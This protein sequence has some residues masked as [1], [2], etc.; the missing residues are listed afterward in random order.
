MKRRLGNTSRRF[1]RLIVES[2]ETRELMAA[3]VASN[4]W[5]DVKNGPLAKTGQQTIELLSKFRQWQSSAA[6]N[7]PNAQFSTPANSLAQIQDNSV[8]MEVVATDFPAA[9]TWLQNNGMVIQSSDPTY[10][11]INGNVPMLN[12]EAIARSSLVGSMRIIERPIVNAV[13]TVGDG[14]QTNVG[15]VQSQADLGQN[16]PSARST[17]A[18]TGAGVKVGVLSDSVSRFQGGLADSQASNNLGA[19]QVI[20]DGPTGSTDEGRAMLELVKD[21]APG[22]PLAFA[23][24]FVGGQTGFANNIDALRT[25]GAKVIVDDITYF[26][27]PMFQP[28]VIDLAIKRAVDANIPYFSS[29][30]NSGTNGL[31]LPVTGTWNVGTNYDFLAGTG[32][33]TKLRVTISSS[34]IFAFQ[35]DDPYNGIAAPG[36][37]DTDIDMFFYNTAGSSIGSIITNNIATGVP[38]EVFQ[39]NG[40]GSFDVSLK[41]NAGTKPTRMKLVSFD[42]NITTE[43]AASHS[44]TYGHNAGPW[45]I[46]VGAVPFYEAP[47]FSPTLPIL[48]E[49]FTSTGPSTYVYDGVTQYRKLAKNITY[50][51]PFISGID[52]ANT[53]FFGSDI[54]QDSDSF[55][56]FAGT[57]AAAPN[58]AAVAAL[59]KQKF[60]TARVNQIAQ[61]L[62]DSARPVNGAADGV[63]NN[64]GGY[65][66]IDAKAALTLLQTTINAGQVVDN[67]DVGFSAPANWANSTGASRYQNDGV[68]A[69]SSTTVTRAAYSF[70]Y[71]PKGTY[72]VMA[73]W[74]PAAAR[75]NAVKY[76]FFDGDQTETTAT[77]NQKVAPVGNSFS[78][79]TWGAIKRVV[80]TQG[81]LFVNVLSSSTGSVSA[82]AI[83]LVFVSSSVAAAA[84]APLVQAAT[85]QNV[86]RMSSPE[87]ESV[88]LNAS[89]SS[90]A[91]PT[92]ANGQTSKTSS[93]S[94]S[95]SV[96]APVPNASKSNKPNTL[97]IDLAL[98]TL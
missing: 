15:S 51:N 49:S 94:V 56:N 8:A 30:G 78:G 33:D 50:N 4:D 52:K 19:V 65:G 42:G 48:T 85:S 97:A 80:I 69:P 23:T 7:S 75:S 35:W 60:P 93:A 67:G 12:L 54:P 6:A 21:I 90:L 38:G 55:P 27:E 22:S 70:F 91:A 29:A 63:W 86:G 92:A 57:S 81:S 10:S 72:D 88:A 26:A 31:E 61:A 79:L 53:S 37:V 3:D 40:S 71:L 25:A 64:R 36:K 95:S 20:Q 13:Q 89:Q 18:V 83:R 68:I 76:E 62:A 58:V 73:R 17:F 32:V 9:L 28:G 82:D 59:M 39:F 14:A 11:V 45:T 2:L 96:S 24:A 5:L 66:L 46:G 44:S 87:G 77:V 41:L 98:L 84:A 47:A 43:Y 16:G 1:R 34:T 74:L